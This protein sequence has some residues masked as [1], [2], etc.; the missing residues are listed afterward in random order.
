MKRRTGVITLYV[1]QSCMKRMPKDMTVSELEEIVSTVEG[2]M[3]GPVVEVM[4][5]ELWDE[6]DSRTAV[7]E[8]V[9]EKNVMKAINRFD[10]RRMTGHDMC[11]RCIFVD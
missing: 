2:V 6:K 9:H 11:V 5:I 7:V 3:Y 4:N 8:Y 10:G 1:A